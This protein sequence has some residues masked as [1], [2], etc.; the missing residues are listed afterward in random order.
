[1]LNVKNLTG[2]YDEKH[3]IVKGINF[4]VEKG[5]FLGVLGP[6]GSGKSTLLK[7]ISGTLPFNQGN[8]QIEGKSREEYTAKELARKMAVLPQLHTQA[9]SHSVRETVSIGRYPY[10]HRWL[11][12]WTD[13]DESAIKKAMESTGILSYEKQ[14]LEN[15]SGGEQQRTYVAQALAQSADLL[16]LDEPTN[17]LDIEHQRKLLDMIRLEVVQNGLTVLSIFH[18]INLAAL[19]CDRLLLLNKGEIY[20]MGE[21][22]EVLKEHFIKDVYHTTIST[23][24]HPL[25]PKPQMTLMP[26]IKG[27]RKESVPIK[28][29][30][31]KI[32]DEYVELHTSSP[33]KAFSS[34][35]HNAGVGWYQYFVNRTVDA[36]YM[37]DDAHDEL[38]EYLMEKGFSP[39]NTVAMMTAVPAKNAVVR[40]FTSDEADIVVAVTAGVGNAIDIASA[41]KREDVFH[42]G[43]I[44]IWV[45]IN[46]SLTDE[47]FMQGMIAITEAKTK[48]MYTEQIKDVVSG[49]IATGTSTDSVLIAATQIGP[50]YEYAGSATAV[51]KLIGRGVYETL[52]TALQDYKKAKEQD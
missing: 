7:A 41:Y 46:G 17:H 5:Q 35:V 20:A 18:D 51:G 44:N 40:Q 50:F 14:L 45:F 13:E 28:A 39:T 21:P 30:D 42:V 2:G 6:N 3:P 11:S 16:L 43:T 47:S 48:A 52:C 25:L 49:T 33:L 4:S 23:Y 1:M 29:E 34:A 38:K 26:E 36:E 19:Y 9:F 12:T 37:C 15:L 32:R 31:I 24:P 10:Q 27:E 8:V 22:H